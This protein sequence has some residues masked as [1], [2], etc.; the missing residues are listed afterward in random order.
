MLLVA[1]LARV[2]KEQAADFAHQE[3]VAAAWKI[4]E[5][6]AIAA[7]E[8]IQGHNEPPKKVE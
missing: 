6:H 2:A 8:E 1:G 5:K 4:V 3:H 7:N